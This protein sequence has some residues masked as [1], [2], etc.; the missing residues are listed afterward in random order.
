M[1]LKVCCVP[2]RVTFRNHLFIYRQDLGLE[3]AVETRLASDSQVYL[4]C[5]LKS[6]SV[7]G[8]NLSSH[9]AQAPCFRSWIALLSSHDVA[10]ETSVLHFP[11]ETVACN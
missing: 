3:L 8:L 4:P 11:T 2:G 9:Q 6:E 1:L 7:E 10:L 5:L